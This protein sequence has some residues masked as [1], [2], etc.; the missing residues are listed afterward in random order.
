MG[1]EVG[2]ASVTRTRLN[3]IDEIT[4][5]GV[6]PEDF[7]GPYE[8]APEFTHLY[9]KNIGKPAVLYLGFVDE[10]GVS[11]YRWLL[12]YGALEYGPAEPTHFGQSGDHSDSGLTFHAEYMF[13]SKR[14]TDSPPLHEGKA[15][16]EALKSIAKG[17]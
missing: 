8:V 14:Y 6:S 3:K 12:G 13:Q 17:V 4:V 5:E 9:V 15:E 1:K 11:G 10:N 7:N 16:K 2:T